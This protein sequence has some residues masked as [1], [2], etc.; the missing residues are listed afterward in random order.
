M[1]TLVTIPATIEQVKTEMDGLG[2]LLT[3]TEWH[4]AAIVYAFT[5][6]G[7]GERTDRTSLRATGG[8][9]FTALAK[10]G[11]VGLRAP[12]TVSRY[13]DAWQSAIASDNADSVSPGDQITL[14]EIDFPAETRARGV[15]VDD[16]RRVSL[17]RK[18]EIVDELLQEPAVAQRYVESGRPMKITDR[19]E[20]DQPATPEPLRDPYGIVR[21]L[22]GELVRFFERPVVPGRPETREQFIRFLAVSAANEKMEASPVT[23]QGYDEMIA[24]ALRELIASATVLLG[25]LERSRLTDGVR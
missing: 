16:V 24:V 19:P 15:S 10:Q 5:R 22:Q 8:L 6:N 18:A 21:T 2:R 1:T 4:R 7:Q 23:R 11:I 14:P 13:R 9:T 25:E 3:A 17:D 20:P 12:E